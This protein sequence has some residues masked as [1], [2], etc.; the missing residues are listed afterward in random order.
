MIDWNAILETVLKVIISVA[1]PVLLKLAL[2]WLRIQKTKLEESMD[3]ET[4]YLI[5]EAVRIAVLAAEQ[6]NLAGLIGEEYKGRKDYA[7]AMAE[8]W[9]APYGITIDLDVLAA[10]IEAA[11]M[12]EFNRDKKMITQ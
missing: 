11:V 7:L 10:M 3:S 12:E 4:R 6:S 8:K 1:L 5:K 9:L 2:D